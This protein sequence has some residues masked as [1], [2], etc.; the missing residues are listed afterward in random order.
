MD[1]ISPDF[2]SSTTGVLSRQSHG[3]LS[4]SFGPSSHHSSDVNLFEAC[5]GFQFFLNTVFLGVLCIFGFVGNTISFLVF[6]RD[7]HNRVPVFLLQSLVVADNSVL[8]T[9]F[10]ALSVFYGLVPV[11]GK[12]AGKL[13]SPYIIRYLNPLACVAQSC[14]IWITVLLAIN[15]YL[16][17]C[18][19]FTSQ[20]WLTMTRARIQVFVVFFLS[21]LVNI[22]RIFVEEIHRIS[23]S[24]NSTT[25]STTVRTPISPYSTSSSPSSAETVTDASDSFWYFEVVYLNAF[26]TSLILILPL[27]LLVGFNIPLL[28]QLQASKRKMIRNSLWYS[29][30][31]ENNITVVMVIIILE[32]IT[33]HTPDRVVQIIKFFSSVTNRGCPRP[34]YYA[35]NIANFLVILNSSMDFIVYYVFRNRFRTILCD[36]VLCCHRG[37]SRPRSN[38]RDVAAWNSRADQDAHPLVRLNSNGQGASP[39]QRIEEDNRDRTKTSPENIHQTTSSLERKND[40]LATEHDHRSVSFVI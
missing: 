2:S 31:Q 25:P 28:H 16:A 39:V 11:S 8:C 26:Y 36:Q 4:G 3:N 20:K 1:S 13:A 15:R 27:L 12:D 37:S 9:S 7:R 14:T 40:P 32:M 35:V 24:A 17:V 23:A 19:P 5:S 29:G 38:S 18:R 22:P 33:C 21:V 30:Q 10:I 34:L 6:Q